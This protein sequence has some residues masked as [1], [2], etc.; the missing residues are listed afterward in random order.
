MSRHH[1]LGGKAPVTVF[2]IACLLSAGCGDSA[3]I[4]KRKLLA[5]GRRYYSLK[6]Y[7]EA[8]IMFRS[9]LKRDAKLGEAY[10]WEGLSETKLGRGNEAAFALRRA[11]ELMPEGA[12]R[13]DARIRLGDVLMEY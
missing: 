1:H 13:V 8:S 11:V 5:S 10:Y 3:D 7:R 4:S 9:A 12:E 6:R 2:L